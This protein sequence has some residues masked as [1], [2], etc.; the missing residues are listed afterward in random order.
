MNELENRAAGIHVDATGI[1][2]TVWDPGGEA[3]EAQARAP[4]KA[5]C[6]PAAG[7][8]DKLYENSLFLKWKQ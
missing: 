1:S 6:I 4:W 2:E 3:E 5:K 7:N 8:S